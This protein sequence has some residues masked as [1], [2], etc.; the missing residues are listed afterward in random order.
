MG[1]IKKIVYRGTNKSLV[2]GNSYTFK[3]FAAVAGVSYRCFVSRAY[4]KR[5]ISDK[6]LEPLN[7][8]K[9]PNRWRNKPDTNAS[10]HETRIGVICQEWLSKKL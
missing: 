9:I 1:N 6:E 8:H 3:E 5:F 10:R 2:S 7:A 4:G